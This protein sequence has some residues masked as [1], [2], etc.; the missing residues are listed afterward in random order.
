MKTIDKDGDSAYCI[1]EGGYTPS[2]FARAKTYV[3]HAFGKHFLCVNY[4]GYYEAMHIMIWMTLNNSL[5]KRELFHKKYNIFYI[6]IR[7]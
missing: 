6:R 5:T 3:L 7:H 4:Y 2:T 1:Y